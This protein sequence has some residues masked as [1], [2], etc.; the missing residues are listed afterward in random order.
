MVFR[1]SEAAKMVCVLWK[2]YKLTMCMQCKQSLVMKLQKFIVRNNYNMCFV[3]L[4][5]VIKM[6]KGFEDE[7]NTIRHQF[8]PLRKISTEFNSKR[9][10][11]SVIKCDWVQSL[12]PNWRSS[13]FICCCKQFSCLRKNWFMSHKNTVVTLIKNAREQWGKRYGVDIELGRQWSQLC[14]II[15]DDFV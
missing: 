9:L 14:L 15:S 11:M 13:L 5:T 4:M 10:K 1:H 8:V 12:V 2:C 6:L 3:K 7:A